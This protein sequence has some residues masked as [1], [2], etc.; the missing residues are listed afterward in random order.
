MKVATEDEAYTV[1]NMSTVQRLKFQIHLSDAGIE[2]TTRIL[3][4]ME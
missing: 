2:A 3:S 1:A 4:D